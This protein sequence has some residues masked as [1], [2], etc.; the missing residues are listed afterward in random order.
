[1]R[2]VLFLRDAETATIAAFASAGTV[3]RL[4]TGN[5]LFRE[6]DPA[7]PL[8]VVVSGM[9]KLFKWDARGRELTLGIARPGD[10]VGAP[11]VFDGGN[12]PYHAAARGDA[13]VFTLPRARFLDFLS[14]HPGVAGGVIRLLAVQNRRLI[15]ML[16]A[17]AL[18]TVRAR[19]AAYLLAAAGNNDTFALPETNAGIAA[20]LGTVREVVSR[21][22]HQFA[23][24]GYVCVRGRT[25]MLLDRAALARDATPP[26]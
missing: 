11:A 12:C 21:I 5:E 15:E 18:H 14:A 22:L 17:Q 3:R 8:Y 16:K 7:P 24:L 23:D 6:H 19:F 9:V 13:Q 25:V 1:M 20:H 26:V 4:G 10:V 2:R